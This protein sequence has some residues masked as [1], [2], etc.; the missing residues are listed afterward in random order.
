MK[1]L[2]RLWPWRIVGATLIFWPAWIYLPKQRDALENAYGGL[3][4]MAFASHAHKVASHI[5][6]PQREEDPDAK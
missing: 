5:K 2:L 3:I 1:R 4:V 6:R